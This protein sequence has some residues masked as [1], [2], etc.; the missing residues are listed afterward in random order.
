MRSAGMPIPVSRTAKSIRTVPASASLDFPRPTA[1]RTSPSS[2]NFTALFNRLRSTCFS[3]VGS[4]T[5]PR[6]TSVAIWQAS[7]MPFSSALGMTSST[8]DSIVSTR[9]ISSSSRSR[10]PAST[11]EKSRMSLMI[12][13]SVSAASPIVVVKSRCSASR[14]VEARRLLIPMIPFRGVRISWLM[15]ARKELFAS[16]AASAC[17]LA[18]VISDSLC[19]S[20]LM[21]EYT[22]TE[23][24]SVV[25]RLS[26]WTQRPS[27]SFRSLEDR[28]GS[29]ALR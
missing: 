20:S 5:T 21:S 23:P 4:P 24:P 28:D 18:R 15:V 11:F 6:G 25:R 17:S 19:F 26:I 2:V 13:S 7:S 12:V 10:A 16:F 9:S 1:R 14:S 8:A 29:E 3:R 27:F 22:T